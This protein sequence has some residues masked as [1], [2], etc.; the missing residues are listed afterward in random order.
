MTFNDLPVNE[1]HHEAK[2][3]LS[4]S[5]SWKVRPKDEGVTRIQVPPKV[6]I[7]ENACILVPPSFE[8]LTMCKAHAKKN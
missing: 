2:S 6:V 1:G 5:A 4:K 8:G 3:K 7:E